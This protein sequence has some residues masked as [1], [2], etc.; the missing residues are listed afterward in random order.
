M[1]QCRFFPNT[2]GVILILLSIGVSSYAADTIR[3][4]PARLAFIT[5][6]T[7]YVTNEIEADIATDITDFN[8]EIRY[9]LKGVDPYALKYQ[10]EGDHHIYYFEEGQKVYTSADG[11]TTRDLILTI[12][13]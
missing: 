4:N 13:V 9:S 7:V 11:T 2:L 12:P 10:R 1:R 5:D 3:L 6:E 8:P